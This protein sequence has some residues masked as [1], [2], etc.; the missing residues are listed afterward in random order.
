MIIARARARDRTTTP[1]R[2]GFMAR[3]GALALVAAA[4]VGTGTVV[5]AAQSAAVGTTPPPPD[6]QAV[7]DLPET[8]SPMPVPTGSYGYLATHD[9]TK[10]MSTMKVADSIAALPVPAQYRPANLGLA[11][12]LDRAVQGALADPKGCVQIIVNPRSSSGGLFD[13]GVYAVSGQYCS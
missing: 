7:V 6:A 5:G 13:Y 3:R 10:R 1:T 8:G 9:L 12:T 2:A 11:K 4:A